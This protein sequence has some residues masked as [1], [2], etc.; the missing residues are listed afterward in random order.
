MNTNH[1]VVYTRLQWSEYFK[2]IVTTDNLYD[3]T[4]GCDII[5]NTSQLSQFS[6]EENYDYR[7]KLMYQM[8][9]KGISNKDIPD[10][11]NKQRIKP[12]RTERYTTKLVW[13]I[14]QKYTNKLN[15]KDHLEVEFKN[16]G[17]YKQ[18]RN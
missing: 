5:I 15:R 13:A 11:L 8:I 3:Y 10:Y 9:Q 4:L 17:L 16:I 6:Q 1:I 12:K 7:E 2:N 14:F 18:V